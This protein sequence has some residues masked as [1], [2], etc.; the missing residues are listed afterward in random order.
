MISGLAKSEAMPRE[1]FF[2]TTLPFSDE[3]VETPIVEAAEVKLASY[4]RK[5]AKKNRTTDE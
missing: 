5:R 2:V 3:R 4:N 1:D